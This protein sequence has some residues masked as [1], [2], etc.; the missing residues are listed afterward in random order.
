MQVMSVMIN[1]AF[2]SGPTIKPINLLISPTGAAA[3]A[4][5]WLAVINPTRKTRRP[6]P[7]DLRTWLFE[8]LH[9]EGWIPRSCTK[10]TVGLIRN[11]LDEAVNLP[12][13]A[14][15]SELIRDLR[16]RDTHYWAGVA[17]KYPFAPQI[18][19]I[20]PRRVQVAKHVLQAKNSSGELI[21]NYQVQFRVD[22]KMLGRTF[23]NF[24]N[25]L[26]YRNRVA[27]AIHNGDDPWSVPMLIA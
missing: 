21:D 10:Q 17:Y 11:L 12:Q 26:D 15:R 22:G 24:A 5:D 20:A 1:I 25:A 27:E 14:D 3:C 4:P 6:C 9:L 8:Q 2:L 23:T 19:R 16:Q 18:G 13:F 7:Q